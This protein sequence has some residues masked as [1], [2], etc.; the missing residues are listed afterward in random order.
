[1][2]ERPAL[3]YATPPVRRHLISDSNVRLLGALFI[4]AMMIAF[5]LAVGF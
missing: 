4:M 1:M 2:S 3:E 5:V